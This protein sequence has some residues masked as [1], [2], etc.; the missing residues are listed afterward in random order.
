MIKKVRFSK[1]SLIGF[2]TALIILLQMMFNYQPN[3]QNVNVNSVTVERVIDGDTIQLKGG[4]KI[5][6]I[7]IN[8]PELHDPRRPVECFA[9]EAFEFNKQLVE[10]KTVILE[11]DVSE[12]DKFKRLLR[13]VWIG[14]IFVNDY[15]VRQGFAEVSTFPPDVKYANQFIEAEKEAR[16]QNRGLWKN[17]PSL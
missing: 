16:D 4:Q 2:T 1:K 6:Y 17:C 7:G 8:T 13:Y 9:K 15:L 5:R 12:T 11:K 14:D 10:G 3:N